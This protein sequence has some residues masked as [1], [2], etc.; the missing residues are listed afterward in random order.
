MF[1]RTTITNF[2]RLALT[3]A[4]PV[5]LFAQVASKDPVIPLPLIDSRVVQPKARPESLTAEEK[6]HL[7]LRNTFGPRAIGNRMIVAGFDMVRSKPEEW[8]GGID[9]YGMRFGSRMGRLAVRNAVRLSTDVAF[10]I[11]PRYDRC[12]CSGFLARTGHA[13]KRVVISR[14][15]AGNDMPAFSNFTGAYVTPFI[16]YTW[17]PDRLDT[18][19]RKIDSGT[20]NLGWRGVSNMI[21][22]FWP[23]VKRS[24]RRADD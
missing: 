3:F 16:T 23:D 20:L 21:K 15:D 19:R 11:D 13:W 4:V 17:Y 10:G 7:A 1:R 18:T 8:G 24:V 12:A 14:S 22:E 9:A 5:G 6:A 2:G